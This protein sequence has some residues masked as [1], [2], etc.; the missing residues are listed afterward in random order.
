MSWDFENNDSGLE[1]SSIILGSE[2]GSYPWHEIAYQATEIGFERMEVTLN[3]EGIEKE[4]FISTFDN[5]GRLVATA[6]YDEFFDKGQFCEVT[7]S[8]D[9]LN[10]QQNCEAS[11]QTWI[12]KYRYSDF[13]FDE[14]GN[15]TA[16]E[17]VALSQQDAI[18][19]RYKI[20]IT[21]Y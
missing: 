15:V 21:Y 1:I 10:G 18:Q 2:N 6:F 19:D 8:E 17:V 20:D 5:E 3:S 12:T 14:A 13:T 4:L 11:G 9:S 16:F 7:Y